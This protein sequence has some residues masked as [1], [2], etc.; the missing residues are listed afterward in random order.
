MCKKKKLCKCLKLV[1]KVSLGGL[2]EFY[3]G[4]YHENED[5]L[6]FKNSM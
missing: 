6:I 4:K 3:K 2:D 1:E 5:I